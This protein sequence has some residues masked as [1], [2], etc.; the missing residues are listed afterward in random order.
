MGYYI[1][2]RGRILTEGGRQT[3][4]P[5]DTSSLHFDNHFEDK[6]RAFY[7]RDKLQEEHP[8]IFLKTKSD[9]V[10]SDAG[11]NKKTLSQDEFRELIR[12]RLKEL[13][14]LFWQNLSQLK[15]RE[16]VDAYMRLLQYGY[17]RAPEE[18]P[19]DEEGKRK[20]VLEETTR[21]AT[22]IESGLP[23]AEDFESEEE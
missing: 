16:M 6:E 3:E 13:E 18:R 22:L 2:Q 19:L 21:K 1:S 17:S 10:I 11:N 23:P 15:P 20:L 7:F 14:P 12:K 4:A 8:R 5:L 9:I